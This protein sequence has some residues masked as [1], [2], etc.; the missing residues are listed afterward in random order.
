MDAAAAAF[1]A[2]VAIGEAEDCSPI[3]GFRT[4][5][6]IWTAFAAHVRVRGHDFCEK[7]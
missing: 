5:A 3:G 4:P 2:P 7:Q 6:P 1:A